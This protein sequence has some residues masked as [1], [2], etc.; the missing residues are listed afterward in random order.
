MKQINLLEKELGVRLFERTHQGLCLTNA[1]HTLY[2]A[3]A[4]IRETRSV[5]ERVQNAARGKKGNHPYRH[6]G[7]QSRVVL[8]EYWQKVYREMRDI[9]IRLVSF[10]TDFERY[11]VFSQKISAVRST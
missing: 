4:L 11:G 6:V 8:L 1:G 3:Q 2:H 10:D 7:A 9:D 5:E